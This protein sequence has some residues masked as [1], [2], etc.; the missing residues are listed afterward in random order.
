MAACWPWHRYNQDKAIAHRGWQV[1]IKTD[2][3]FSPI[4]RGVK[5][6]VWCVELEQHRAA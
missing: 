1:D 2:G 4:G 6:T 3:Y 5:V